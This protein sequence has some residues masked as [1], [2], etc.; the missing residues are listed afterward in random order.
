MKRCQRVL[1]AATL[2]LALGVVARE[3]P[4]IMT[5]SDDWSNEGITSD[6]NDRACGAS[7]GSPSRMERLPRRTARHS[8]ITGAN[9]RGQ[10]IPLLV[11]SSHAGKSLLR[12]ISLQRV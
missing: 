6:L 7:F 9:R 8:V 2:L 11:L 5:L 12:F 1:L 4:E 10:H 3:I